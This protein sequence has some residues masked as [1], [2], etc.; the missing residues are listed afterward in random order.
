MFERLTQEKAQKLH[1]E[2]ISNATHQ[3]AIQ[4]NTAPFNNVANRPSQTVFLVV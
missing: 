1:K 3:R 2:D 4:Q